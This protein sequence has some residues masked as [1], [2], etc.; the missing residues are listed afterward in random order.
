MWYAFLAPKGT[1]APIVARLNSELRTILALPE[2]KSAFEKQGL[3]AA[4]NSSAE[5]AAL[6][7][8]DYTRWAL[9]IKKN[10]ISAD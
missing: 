7:K 9:I 4:S 5:M 6:M 8:K 2:V 3:D 10:N 1:P